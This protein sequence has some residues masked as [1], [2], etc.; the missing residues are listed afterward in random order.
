MRDRLA[1]EAPFGPFGWLA[2][3]LI[4]CAYF[5]RFLSQRD[6]VIKRI[7]ESS[8]GEWQEYLQNI[9]LRS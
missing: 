5:T 9:G 2:E 7:A 3:R 4:L 1:F 6:A 8:S